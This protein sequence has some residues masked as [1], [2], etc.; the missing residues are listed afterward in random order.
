MFIDN[1]LIYFFICFSYGQIRGILIQPSSRQMEVVEAF[2]GVPYASPPTGT[3]R[4]RLP[5]PPVKWSGIRL[6]DKFGAVCPQRFP[7]LT[8]QTATLELMPPGRLIQVQRFIPFLT[9]QS[10]DCLNLNVYVPGSGKLNFFFSSNLT[11]S[12]NNNNNK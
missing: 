5:Q 12:Y 6:A 11:F 3:R 7:D 4:F 2:L 8:N 9:N 1:N 10:E